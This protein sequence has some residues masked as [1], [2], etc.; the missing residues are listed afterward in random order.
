MA[1]N[2]SSATSASQ[3]TTRRI[4]SEGASW[5]HYLQCGHHVEPLHTDVCLDNCVTKPP[6]KQSTEGVHRY[7]C[8]Q[9][10]SQE[11]TDFSQLAKHNGLTPQQLRS[12]CDKWFHETWRKRYP[13]QPCTL[14]NPAVSSLARALF[15]LSIEERDGDVQ[16]NLEGLLDQ[17]SIG[18]DTN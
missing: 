3:P 16:I 18:T 7:R 13:T 14:T 17:L 4:C 10:L 11:I 15:S 9:C 12:A 8:W 2:S 5:T 1:E 6:F